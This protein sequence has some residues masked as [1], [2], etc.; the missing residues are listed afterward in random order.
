MHPASASFAGNLNLFGDLCSLRGNV[1]RLA[2][3]VVWELTPEAEPVHLDFTKSIICSRAA[4]TYEAAQN[5]IDGTET[6]EV[7]TALR[8]LMQVARVLR[9]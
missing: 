6:D 4:L 1:E 9:R 7:T 2:F 3:S 5:R 8:L